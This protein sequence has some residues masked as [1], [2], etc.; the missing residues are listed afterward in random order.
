MNER[1][2]LVKEVRELLSKIPKG[3]GSVNTTLVVTELAERYSTPFEV[4]RA[5][6]IIEAHA[7]GLSSF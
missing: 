4:I 3:G 7:A 6:V 2:Q 5:I 1:E